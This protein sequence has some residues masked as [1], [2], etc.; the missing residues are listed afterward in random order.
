VNTYSKPADRSPHIVERSAPQLARLAGLADLASST[1]APAELRIANEPPLGQRR[2][3][4]VGL[5][6]ER[7]DEAALL[8][9]GI[10]P[11]G[12]G[13][14]RVYEEFR[15]VQDQVLRLLAAGGE[16]TGQDGQMVMV[17]SAAPGEG[18]SF[19]SANLAASLAR[20]SDRA[21]LLVDTDPK[22]ASLSRALGLS[23]RPGLL[24]IAAGRDEQ[25]P[26]TVYSTSIEGL[27]V[28]PLGGEATHRSMLAA[29]GLV[30]GLLRR[31]SRHFPTHVIV[32]DAPPCLASSDAS[33]L[34]SLVDQIVVV[35]EAGKTQQDELEAALDLIQCCRNIALLL[36]KIRSDTGSGF[37]SYGDYK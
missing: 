12:Q 16:A 26:I 28:L 18:K 3:A 22:P 15:I 31:L 17:T 27:A 21:V 1:R 2:R 10:V 30:P 11:L 34:A 23:G 14:S 37:G 8:R 20:C 36:N 32:L 4:T 6:P 7:V 25:G 19:V 24:D 9:A 33:M 5:A 13:R 35:I 29:T